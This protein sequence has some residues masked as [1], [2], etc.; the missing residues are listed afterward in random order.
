MTSLAPLGPARHEAVVSL[1]WGN[2]LFCPGQF[3]RG[4][5]PS[6]P[7]EPRD[8]D[9]EFSFPPRE[10]ASPCRITKVSVWGPWKLAKRSTVMV[11]PAAAL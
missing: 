3:E 11:L 2:E 7:R 5:F 1:P 6:Q 4:L 10:A 8:P 9:K